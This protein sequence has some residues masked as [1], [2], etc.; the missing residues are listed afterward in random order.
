MFG[1]KSCLD[2]S[3]LA[4]SIANPSPT[5]GYLI[6]AGLSSTTVY[7]VFISLMSPTAL[8]TA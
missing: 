4:K 1:T 3:G 6:I 8:A 2:P 7:A 5:C